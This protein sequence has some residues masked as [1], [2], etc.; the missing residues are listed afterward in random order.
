MFV[1]RERVYAYSVLLT[2]LYFLEPSSKYLNY[3]VIHCFILASESSFVCKL[4]CSIHDSPHAYF[5][6]ITF[7]FLA[8]VGA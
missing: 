7:L 5:T 2:M 1:I 6:M 4:S 8:H 3:S